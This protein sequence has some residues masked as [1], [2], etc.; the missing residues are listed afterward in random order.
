MESRFFRIA[1]DGD[2]ARVDVLRERLTEEDNVEEFGQELIS[3]VEKQKVT[4]VILGMD[5]VKYFT[6]S[7][8]GKLIMLHR[9]MGRSDGELVLARLR[10]EAEEILSTSQLLTYFHTDVP[11]GEA[12]PGL[13]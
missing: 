8:I 9:R 2:V 12:K 1:L 10:P 11:P 6:S 4:K 7:V 5:R 3:L 13:A